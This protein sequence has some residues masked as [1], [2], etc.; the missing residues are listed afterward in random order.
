[1]FV[2]AFRG[3]RGGAK[4]VDAPPSNALSLQPRQLASDPSDSDSAMTSIKAVVVGDGATGKVSGCDDVLRCSVPG[5][6]WP[7]PASR[8]EPAS[9]ADRRG[10]GGSSQR[11]WGQRAPGQGKTFSDQTRWLT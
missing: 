2:K 10:R 8:R 4:D 6:R 5:P 9:G 1:M 3:W 11:G 7:R